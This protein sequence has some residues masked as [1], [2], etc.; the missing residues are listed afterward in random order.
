MNVPTYIVGDS[1]KCN[2]RLHVGSKYSKEEDEKY[3]YRCAAFEDDEIS[4]K[5]IAKFRRK[6]SEWVMKNLHGEINQRHTLVGVF[7]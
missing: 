4:I 7:N 2:G 1:I 5:N 6:L 3:I